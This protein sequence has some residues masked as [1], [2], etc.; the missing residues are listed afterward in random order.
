M[1]KTAGDKPCDENGMGERVLLKE[2]RVGQS[3]VKAAGRADGNVERN[4]KACV[5]TLRKLK[6]QCFWL[7][8]NLYAPACTTFMHSKMSSLR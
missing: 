8:P 7:L 4:F 3:G 1:E 2:G 6:I 5:L